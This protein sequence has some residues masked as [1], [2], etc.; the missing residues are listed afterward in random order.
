M[1]GIGIVVLTKPP[2]IV[3]S[4]KPHLSLLVILTQILT[5]RLRK[6]Q[7]K[8]KIVA[9]VSQLPRLAVMIVF[10]RTG[11]HQRTISLTP[12]GRTLDMAHMSIPYSP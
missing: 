5:S 10:K 2:V 11:N 6:D 7:Q 3:E 9:S 4:S 12:V 8:N 1:T